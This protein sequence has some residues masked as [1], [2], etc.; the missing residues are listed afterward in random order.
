MT[1]I[2]T[3]ALTLLVAG[4]C[5]ALP[6]GVYIPDSLSA[7]V[8]NPNGK[9]V[10]RMDGF[11]TWIDNVIAPATPSFSIPLS[12]AQGPGDTI[13]V[14]DQG[15]D[16]VQRFSNTGVYLGVFINFG[17]GTGNPRG[18]ARLKSGNYLISL[19]DLDQVVE[20]DSNGNFVKVFASVSKPWF[21]V[22]L[23][24]GDVLVS[25]STAWGSSEPTPPQVMRYSSTG[26]PLGV[27]V[28]G[29]PFS[30]Q[31]H[32]LADGNILVS[33]FSLPTTAHPD[34]GNALYEFTP[35]GVEVAKYNV[36]GPRGCMELTDG[37]ILTTSGTVITKF[38][39][40]N[41]T[42]TVLSGFGGGTSSWR[43]IMN[44]N[45]PAPIKLKAALQGFA[46]DGNGLPI[47]VTITPTTGSP[48]SFAMT[49]SSASSGTL[50]NPIT[51]TK[52]TT[53]RGPATIDIRG[54]RC[55]SR[56]LNVNLDTWGY[57]SSTIQLLAGDANADDMIDLF[58]YLILSSGY[59]TS[60]PDP[61]YL[62]NAGADFNMDGTI[63]FF[64]YLL[65]SE[66]YEKEGEAL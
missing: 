38:A 16:N 58:D 29:Y 19:G 42:G 1:K 5:V 50:G 36:Q 34:K 47:N 45:S 2:L 12:C 14:S 6:P 57:E 17:A 37:S 21:P 20:Y 39:R 66:N 56:R 52:I 41:P 15:N 31:V 26:L 23:R 33:V 18:I 61:G 53:L 62:V 3:S 10:M 27:F 8:G 13:L 35:A 22:Q 46:G 49:G 43:M 40:G 54:P 65:L 11:G 30:Q 9:R 51:G 60:D 4:V 63:D 7:S 59:E 32:E 24:N 44:T 28:E 64:D 48:V 25:R 55:L